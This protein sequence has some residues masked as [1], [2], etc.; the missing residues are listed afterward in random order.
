MKIGFGYDSHRLERKSGIITLGGVKEKSSFSVVAHSDG[1]V[2]AHA[3]ID[4]IAPLFI[5]KS[6]GEIY[7]DKDGNNTKA[8]SMKRLRDVYEMCLTPCIINIDIIIQ[9]DQVNI[10]SIADK[11]KANIS[12]I[13]NVSESNIGIKGK[14]TEGLWNSEREPFIQVWAVVLFDS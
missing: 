1:D 2:I 13:L 8:D 6:I 7:S 4:A 10:A 14:T 5:E 3:L 9:T 11:I 12:E